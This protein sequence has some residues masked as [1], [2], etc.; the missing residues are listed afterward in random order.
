MRRGVGRSGQAVETVTEGKPSARRREATVWRA[1]SGRLQ[2]RERCA[3]TMWRRRPAA[4][5]DEVNTR[6][7][8]LTVEGQTCTVFQY[9]R[10][11]QLES[12]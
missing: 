9:G 7:G 4:A 1:R 3:R 10:R 12:A 8:T 11:I 2:S 5:F 6:Q